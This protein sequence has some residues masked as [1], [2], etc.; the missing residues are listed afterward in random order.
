VHEALIRTQTALV[1]HLGCE[2]ADGGV[3]TPGLGQ[4]QPSVRQ[5]PRGL[6]VGFLGGKKNQES[7]AEDR[8]V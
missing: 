8:Q 3:T 4:E 7:V 2:G 5:G 6:L 1:E